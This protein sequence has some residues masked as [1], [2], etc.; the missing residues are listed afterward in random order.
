MLEENGKTELYV[1]CNFF[2]EEAELPPGLIP[3]GA[4]LLLGNYET[5]AGT[6]QG[7]NSQADERGLYEAAA[8]RRLRPYECFIALAQV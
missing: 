4:S 5:E 1:V 7:E 8:G 3:E 2:R 6:S